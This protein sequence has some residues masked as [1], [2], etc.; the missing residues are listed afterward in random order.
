LKKSAQKTFALRRGLGGAG[1]SH[2]RHGLAW[3][4]PAPPRPRRRA[5]VFCA[6][7]FKKALL[8][9]LFLTCCPAFGSS[10][11]SVTQLPVPR[12]VS[13]RT[14]EVNVRAGPGA[15]YPV[16]WVYHR[17]GLPVEIIAEF[18]IWRQIQA[19]DGGTGWVHEATLR[20]RRGFYIIPPAAILR[21]APSDDAG[22]VAT[23]TQGVSGSLLSCA[24]ESLYCK[25]AVGPLSGYLARVAFWGTLPDETVK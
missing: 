11:G 23:L 15:Q 5:K 6:L 22:T 9:L 21:S 1:V 8:A 13:L 10:L 7:F 3:L 2:A 24:P 14:D 19:P 20:A 18:D 4:T 16:I 12:F 17:A 25:V